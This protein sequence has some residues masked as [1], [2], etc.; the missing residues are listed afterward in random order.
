MTSASRAWLTV[1]VL[2]FA[3]GFNFL[4]RTMLTTMHGSVVH[5]CTASTMMPILC[6]IVDPRYRST[7]YGMLNMMGTI[8]G[9][10][11]I[12]LAG[13]L[14]D[15]RVELSLIMFGT[16]ACVAVCPVLLMTMRPMPRR[17][18]D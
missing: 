9:G 10:S 17:T 5:G 11:A 2:W 18:T 14:R 7:G 13:E 1:G 12:Y 6:L 16:V 8:A 4:T 3:G 15:Q